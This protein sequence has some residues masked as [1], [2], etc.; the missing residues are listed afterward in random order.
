MTL[1]HAVPFDYDRIR[2]RRRKHGPRQVREGVRARRG[3][4]CGAGRAV[5]WSW[6]SRWC[7]GMVER[8]DVLVY[9]I[10]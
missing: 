5:G 10:R 7:V 4:M 6:F 9:Y 2:L 8:M 3:C 1:T